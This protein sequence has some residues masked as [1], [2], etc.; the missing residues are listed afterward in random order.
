MAKL[1]RS[2]LGRDSGELSRYS[3]NQY[4]ADLSFAYQGSRYPIGLGSQ[5][6]SKSE[7]IENSFTG[8]IQSVYKQDGPVFAVILARMLLFCEARFCWFEIGEDGE[9]G[10]PAGREGL[11]VLEHP[12]PNA[13]TGELL[14]RMEQDVS[15]GGNFYAVREATRLRRLRPDWLTIVL[16]APP[17]EAVESDV[18][19]YWYH[20]G[21][22]FTN[23]IEAAPGD[24]LYMPEDICHWSPIPDPDA[25]YRGMSWLTPVITEVQADKAATLHKERF[26]ANG[27][28][29]GQIVAPK[30]NLS[31]EQFEEWKDNILSQHQGVDNAYRPFF[32]GSPVDTHTATADMRQL[33]F[34]ITQGAGE[35]RLCA[36]GGVP[37]IIVGLSEGLSSATYS[38]YGMARRKFGDHWGIPQWKSASQALQGVTDGPPRDDLRLGV[39]VKGIAFMRE[40]AKDAAAIAQIQAAT[41]VSLLQGGIEFESA[42]QAV[43][44]GD[45]SLTKWTGMVSVQLQPPGATTPDAAGQPGA[46]GPALDEAT[47][48][49]DAAARALG[50]DTTPGHDE[51]HHYWTRGEGLAKWSGSP[52]PW[53]TLEHHLE[54]FVGPERAKRMAAEWFHEVFGFWPGSDMNRVTHGKPP[55]G[56]LVGPG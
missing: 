37:P 6:W 36:A 38:N 26:F 41:L 47:P 16:T 20:P 1:W 4:A 54:K 45:L 50:H 44:S 42:K 55:R 27:A 13:G 52:T 17:A 49:A 14:A 8:Y 48:V 25:Q 22:S 11:G 29:F 43:V 40:D 7:D 46:P 9:D 21:R 5:A 2:L 31:T 18:A 34:K 12:W 30:E 39:N 3:I 19:G 35:T 23:V 33:D 15:L 56:H 10:R 53:T 51:L 32:L 24:R 28:T